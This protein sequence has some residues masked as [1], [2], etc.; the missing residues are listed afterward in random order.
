[1]HV[2]LGKWAPAQVAEALAIT[3]VTAPLS[4]RPYTVQNSV[5]VLPGNVR[6]RNRPGAPT[7]AVEDTTARS[8]LEDSMSRG[9]AMDADADAPITVHPYSFGGDDDALDELEVMDTM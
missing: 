4:K 6:K 7:A 3:A 1:M 2:A 9:Y 5:V 8:L